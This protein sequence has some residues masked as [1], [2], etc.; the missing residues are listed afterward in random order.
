[1]QMDLRK[2]IQLLQNKHYVLLD[3]VLLFPYSIQT[4]SNQILFNSKKII[5]Q[6]YR[7][8]INE[9]ILYIELN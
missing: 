5:L 3:L 9:I 7:K 6:I 2:Q 4:H 1:M 8:S